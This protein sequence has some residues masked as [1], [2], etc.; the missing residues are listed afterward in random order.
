MSTRIRR[1]GVPRFSTPDLMSWMHDAAN[2][3]WNLDTC[4]HFLAVS[5]LDQH[6][7]QRVHRSAA[8]AIAM[9]KEM[10]PKHTD[11]RRQNRVGALFD[12]NVAAA[13]CVDLLEPDAQRARVSLR[14]MSSRSPAFV[15]GDCVSFQRAV[16]NLVIN[17][18][19]AADP[20]GI[21]TVRTAQKDGKVIVTVTD[22]GSGIP[23]SLR[24]RLLREP[25]T[26]KRR[27]GGRGL[28]SAAATVASQGGTLGIDSGAGRTAIT[29][30]LP[31]AP[32]LPR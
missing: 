2:L 13:A 32:K 1:D 12:V 21:V 16:Y 7:R 3:V 17:G 20:G 11:L 4:L 22:S 14:L 27:G 18:V 6:S 24:R 31:A 15:K 9:L 10:L 23:T 30:A 19:E 25:F 26:T 5:D 8:H 28:L 29:I